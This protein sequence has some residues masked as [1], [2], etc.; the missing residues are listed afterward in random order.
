MTKLLDAVG[1]PVNLYDMVLMTGYYNYDDVMIPYLVLSEDRNSDNHP[2]SQAA[3][4]TKD[5]YDDDDVV[6]NFY[7]GVYGQRMNI[8]YESK[9]ILNTNNIHKR[10]LRKD[11]YVTYAERRLSTFYIG[12]IIE[13]ITSASNN[14]TIVTQTNYKGEEV[15]R[16]SLIPI[17]KIFDPKIKELVEDSYE[18]Y[19]KSKSLKV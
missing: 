18:R 15:P 6:T 10:D 14:V 13:P 3:K 2:I 8:L 7:K 17:K 9:A 16:S 1:N 5:A 4:L 12:K 19:Y 11:D